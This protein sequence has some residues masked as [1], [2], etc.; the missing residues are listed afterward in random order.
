MHDILDILRRRKHGDGF[1]TIAKARK[2]SRNTIR[3]YIELAVTLGFESDSE[4]PLE[5]IAYGVYRKVY[6]DGSRPVSECRKVLI[7]YKEKLEHWLSEERLTMTKIHSLLKRHGVSV[8]YD[9]L[10]RYLHEDLGFFKHNTVRMPETAPGEYAEVDFGRLGLLYDPETDR[11]RVVHALIVTLPYSRYQYVH[12][13]HSMK[14]QEVI[15]GLESA[16]EFFGGVPAKV[17]VDNM[18]TAID[19]ADRYDAQFNRY[20]YEYACY[21]GFIIDPARA[22]APKD[23]PKVERNVSYVRDNFFKGETFRSLSH[24]QEAADA[25]CR[26]VSGMRIHGTTKKHP[27]IVFDMEEQA[28]LL[29]LEQERY[30]VPFWGT[31]KVHPDHHIRIQSALYSVPTVYIGKEVSVRLDSKLVRIYHKEQQIKV[32][33]R[34]KKGKRSTDTSDYPEE[35]RGYTMKSCE[36][37]IYKAKEVGFYCGEFMERLLSGDFPWQN[38]RQAQ[39]LIRDA[40]KYG[41]GRMEQACQRAVSFDLINVYRV[42]NIIELSMQNNEVEKSSCKVLKPA[43]FTRNKNYFYEG[44]HDDTIK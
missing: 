4:P 32:H 40:D 2:M 28:N 23:K 35:K 24:A 37:H 8:S 3:K 1:K 18:K 16:W 42:V 6:G 17:I 38:L 21:R 30:D 19:K 14:F 9:T 44:G 10:R 36:Y 7:P 39:K 22:V 20:F 25:W 41:H 33:S 27:R 34:M 5:E 15:T 12:L 26:T 13:C 11:R 31:C 29:P 43:K